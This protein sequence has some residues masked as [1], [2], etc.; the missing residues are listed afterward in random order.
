MLVLS[1]SLGADH[2]MWNPQMAG[3]T[4]YFRVLRYDT[5]GHGASAVPLGRYTISD[6]GQDVIDLFAALRIERAHFCGLSMGGMVGM[7]LAANA[8]A[9]VGRLALCNTAAT[10]GPPQLWQMRIEA[11]R[12]GAMEA[13]A[14]GVLIRWF[15]AAFLERQPD[16]VAWMRQVLTRTSPEAY[17]ARC[18]AICDM[19]QRDLLPSIPRRPRSSF[20]A[21]LMP[22]QRQLMGDFLPPRFQE[23]TTRNWTWRTCPTSK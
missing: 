5:R 21:R 2:T 17:I 20:L 3:L 22:R 23:P 8:P 9:K 19:D 10:M 16:T 1:H 6:L 7:W 4:R 15:T 18:E 12:N 14:E 11:V 13:I